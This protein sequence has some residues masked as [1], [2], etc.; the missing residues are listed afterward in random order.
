MV[1]ASLVLFGSGRNDDLVIGYQDRVVD[2]ALIL[3]AGE[4][5]EAEGYVFHSFSS[6]SL[7][8][9][10]LLNGEVDAA[11]MGD[12]VAVSLVSRYPDLFFLAGVHGEGASRHRL[13]SREEDLSS[14]K[15]IGV[16]FGTS[17]HLALS[18]WLVHSGLVPEDVRLIDLS[19]EL[20][21]AALGSGE[22]D[23]LASSEPTPSIAEQR[24]ADLTV[25]PLEVAGRHFPVVLAVRKESLEK[26]SQLIDVIERTSKILQ[27]FSQLSSLQREFLSRETRLDEELLKKSIAYHSYGFSTMEPYAEEFLELS[28]FLYDM[29]KIPR[30]PD[31]EHLFVVYA[32]QLNRN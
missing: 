16:K 14:V 8:A 31:W 3:A 18:V 9:E 4:L 5:S 13:A 26:V 12:A 23:A 28:Q 19:P 15:R 25:F 10:A 22:I 17:T 21:L 30:I 7:S 1:A 32:E 20:Q 24:I 11:S 2:A 29:G 6:G 27:D